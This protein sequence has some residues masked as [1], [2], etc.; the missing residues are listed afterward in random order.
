MVR[1]WSKPEMWVPGGYLALVAAMMVWLE[2]AGRTGHDVG[3]GAIWPALATAP[4]SLL[5]LGSF[6][7]A[8]NAVGQD[9]AQAPIVE[10]SYGSQPPG[11][12]PTAFPSVGD[13][14]PSD[15]V[16][17]TSVAGRP[18][19][20]DAFGFYIPILVGALINA[21]VIWAL[22]RCWARWRNARPAA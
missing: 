8:A 13:P 3:M 11:P 16:P 12:M 18:E 4:V 1:R 5:L 17:D 2:V 20:W 21:A 7:A 19:V 10:P 9:P 6:G 14:L 22:L 15:W